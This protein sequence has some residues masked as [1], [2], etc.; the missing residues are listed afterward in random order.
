VH[1]KKWKTYAD[2]NWSF[3]LKNGSEAAFLKITI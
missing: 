1:E 3:F 2:H